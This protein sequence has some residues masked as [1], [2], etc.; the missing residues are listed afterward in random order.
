[1]GN[2]EY[3]GVRSQAPK[4]TP[5]KLLDQCELGHLRRLRYNRFAEEVEK[6]RLKVGEK[7]YLREL[8]DRVNKAR[9]GRL[10]EYVEQT[11]LHI[12]QSPSAVLSPRF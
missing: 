1:M 7:Q 8:L 11:G 4:Q 10:E 3:D 9:D 12:F 2:G 6:E 5:R